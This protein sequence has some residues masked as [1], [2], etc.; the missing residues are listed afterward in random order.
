MKTTVGDAA[1]NLGGDCVLPSLI[2][3]RK[4][5]SDL[6]TLHADRQQHAARLAELERRGRIIVHKSFL[7]RRLDGRV[8]FNDFRQPF[9]QMRQ[10]ARQINARLGFNQA[11]RNK[12]KRRAF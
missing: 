2:C 5:K 11:G 12:F 6:Q 1:M 10:T 8:G 4:S 7:Y 9:M 3:A